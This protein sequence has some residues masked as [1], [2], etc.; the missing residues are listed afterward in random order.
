MSPFDVLGSDTHAFTATDTEITANGLGAFIGFNKAYNGGELPN[1]G[2][3]TQVSTIT[4]EVYEYSNNDGV[5]RITVTIDYGEEPGA[6]YWTM[7]LISE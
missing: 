5:E 4:Y 7:R 1:E 2:T 3:G 6:A